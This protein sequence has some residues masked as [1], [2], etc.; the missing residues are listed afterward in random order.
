M[1][2]HL[3]QSSVLN[4]AKAILLGDF[5][6]PLKLEEEE[7]IQAVLQ[8]FSAEQHCPVL[9]CP[10]IGHGKKNRSLPFGTL[11]HLDLTNNLLTIKK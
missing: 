6:F 1:L 5:I 3:H 4:D 2:Q 11:A 7:K 9:R 10:D 8:R